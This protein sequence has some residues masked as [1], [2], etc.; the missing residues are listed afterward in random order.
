MKNYCHSLF[1]RQEA[2]EEVRIAMENQLDKM[3]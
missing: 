1:Q 3:K 2:I